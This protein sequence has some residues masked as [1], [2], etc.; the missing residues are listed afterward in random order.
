MAP[1]S[2]HHHQRYRGGLGRRSGRNSK[3]RFLK[4]S[5][6]ARSIEYTCQV[7][8]TSAQRSEG[9]VF[10]S[11]DTSRK[12]AQTHARTFDRFC[13]S[14]RKRWLKWYSESTA[15][16]LAVLAIPRNVGHYSWSRVVVNCLRDPAWTCRSGCSDYPP[17]S[18]S[19][20]HQFG[21]TRPIRSSRDQQI[22]ETPNDDD[23]DTVRRIGTAFIRVLGHP[24]PLCVCHCQHVS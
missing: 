21:T 16:F 7:W 8:S 10:E 1:K 15:S 4:I 17:I 3:F 9:F 14:S 2:R 23:D 20:R 18:R 12:D 11:F 24:I 6:H 19:G 5:S 22:T 13:R